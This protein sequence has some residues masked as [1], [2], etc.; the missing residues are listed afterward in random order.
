MIKK[1]YMIVVALLIVSTSLIYAAVPNKIVGGNVDNTPLPLP[2]GLCNGT[3]NITN[4]GVYT[5]AIPSTSLWSGAAPSENPNYGGVYLAARA[6]DGFSRTQYFINQNGLTTLSTTV[7]DIASSPDQVLFSGPGSSFYNLDSSRW[8]VLGRRLTDAA[9]HIRQ[10]VNALTL[11]APTSIILTAGPS[12]HTAYS[13]QLFWLQYS[14]A[15]GLTLGEFDGGVNTKSVFIPGGGSFR[16]LAV[17]DTFVYATQVSGSQIYKWAR[18]DITAGLAGTAAPAWGAGT[19]IGIPTADVAL[20]VLYIPLIGNGI[21]DNVVFRVRTSDLTITGSRSMGV[22]NFLGKVFVDT[23]NNKLYVASSP[24]GG[25]A[26]RLFRLN[27]TTLVIEQSFVATVTTS[28]GPASDQ[29][30][31][32]INHQTLFVPLPDTTLAKMQKFNLCS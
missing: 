16:G 8:T 24:G 21:T 28:D 10:Y 29:S 18:T 19:T 26:A 13:G 32:D 6:I 25:N 4:G 22:A 20:G 9:L 5:A 15:A 30:S 23:A 7:T 2:S 1:L 3:I 31:F 11:D 17:D 12:T 27:R 14:I